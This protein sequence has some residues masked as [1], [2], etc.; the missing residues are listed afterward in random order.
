MS[1][2]NGKGGIALKYNLK[3]LYEDNHLLVVEKPANIPVQADASGDTDFCSVCR[4][5]L[6]EAGNKPGEAYIGLVHRLDRPVGGVMV[7]AK[8]S[9]AAER[10]TKQFKGHEAKKHY[11]AIVDAEAP[12][13]G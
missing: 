4:A 9:K 8:T 6:K 11:A 12:C 3:V 2:E 10:L 1:E 13:E 5:Y 7:F